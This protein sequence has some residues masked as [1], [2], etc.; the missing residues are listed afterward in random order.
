MATFLHRARSTRDQW[1]QDGIVRLAPSAV[2]AMLDIG[3]SDGR[4][5]AAVAEQLEVARVQGV[6]VQMQDDALIDVVVYDGRVLPFAD[7]EFGLVTIV[8]VLH[9]ADDPRAVLA[10]ALR[11]V[12]LQGFVVLKDHVKLSSWSDW[13]LLGMD[14][15]SNYGVHDLTRGRYL[16]MP[17]WVAMVAASGGSIETLEWPF[18]VHGLPW[19][20]V[21][22]DSY[23]LLMA[24]RPAR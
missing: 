20:V 16:S 6:D 9:H 17:E 12:D 18:R 1:I 2:D 24:I 15:A 8:D 23:H 19:R 11:V 7:G 3:C 4:I 5:A 13:V 21:A 10:E 22:R 14:T